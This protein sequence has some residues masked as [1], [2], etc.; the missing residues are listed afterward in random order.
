M[1]EVCLGPQLGS[2]PLIFRD[3]ALLGPREYPKNWSEI[4]DTYGGSFFE[5]GLHV[6]L[7]TTRWHCGSALEGSLRHMAGVG[8]AM[9]P[10]TEP[11]LILQPAGDLGSVCS[12]LPCPD[13]SRPRREGRKGQEVDQ[14]RRRLGPMENLGSEGDR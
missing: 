12:F 7:S 3:G 13:S 4:E 14:E 9:G 10:A 1:S 11:Y 5:A 2:C 6:W 8:P